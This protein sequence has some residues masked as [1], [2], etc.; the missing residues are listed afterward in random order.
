MEVCW[1]A[2]D[3]S[4]FLSRYW[5]DEAAIYDTLTGD[6]HLLE[7]V[8]VEVVA[9]L[10]QGHHTSTDLANALADRFAIS[11]EDDILAVTESTLKRLEAIGIAVAACP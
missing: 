6:T 5:D 2:D 9:M 10:R 4:R 11:P 1:I 8:A 7:P 3:S